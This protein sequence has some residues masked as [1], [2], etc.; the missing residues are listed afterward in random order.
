MSS[1]ATRSLSGPGVSL[2][3][4]TPPPLAAAVT[5]SSG[6]VFAS[7][8]GGSIG[9]SAT[10]SPGIGVLGSHSLNPAAAGA[11]TA[12]SA[13]PGSTPSTSSASLLVDL[14]EWDTRVQL[15]N[16]QRDS[17][18]LLQDLCGQLPIPDKFAS[19]PPA[20]HDAD[21]AAWPSGFNDPP[22]MTSLAARPQP[23]ETSARVDAVESVA[24]SSAPATSLPK[25][26]ALIDP[27]ET[28]HHFLSWYSQIEDLM[29]QGLADVY[30][31]HLATL[32]A[33]LAACNDLLSLV[34]LARSKLDAQST[35]YHFVQT[36]TSSLQNVCEKLLALQQHLA[37]VVEE[38]A[39]RLRRFDVLEPA[40]RLFSATGEG[41]CLDADFVPM[42][43]RLDDSLAFVQQNRGYKDA[44]LYLMK[45]RQCMT[46]GLTLIKLYFASSMRSLFQDIKDKLAN[47]QTNEP[48]PKSL[49]LSLFY[50]K[51][52]R[53]AEHL[54]P[55]IFEL[56]VRC[57]DHPEYYGLR[58]E[59]F[60][61][62]FNTRRALLAPSVAQAVSEIS[63]ES[64]ILATAKRGA[65]YITSLCTDECSL[66]YQ[67]FDGGEDDLAGYLDSLSSALYDHLRPM[68][69][70]EMRIDVLADLC[71]SLQ[72]H[73][74][75]VDSLSSRPRPVASPTD[76]PSSV[77]PTNL[78]GDADRYTDRV[79]EKVLQDAQERLVFR[80]QQYIKEEVEGFKPRDRELEVLARTE[81][82]PQP[83]ALASQSNMVPD[84]TTAGP[85]AVSVLA[86]SSPTTSPE[87]N[88]ST[89][90]ERTISFG[91][92]VYGGG[93]W[94][95]TL[96]RTLYILGKMYRSIPTSIFEDL[97][98]EAI[99]LCR[100]S[101]VSASEVIG[102]KKTR[103]DGQL[104]LI[105][106]LLMLRE[107]IAP[108]DSNF[109]RYEE[110]VDFA[111]LT[112]FLFNLTPTFLR[113]SATLRGTYGTGIKPSSVMLASGVSPTGAS[114]V[115]TSSTYSSAFSIFRRGIP[116]PRVFATATDA[117]A[118]VN[119][120]L[121]RVCED[122]ILETA[123]AVAEPASS[124]MVKVTAFRLRAE[125][126]RI[127][128]LAGSTAQVPAAESLGTLGAQAFAAP[129][130][131]I[132]AAEAV[133]DKVKEVLGGV[134]RKMADYLGDRRTEAVL[135]VHM[136]SN[137]MNAYSAFHNVVVLEHDPALLE[138]LPSVGAMSRFV[139]EVCEKAS[140]REAAAAIGTAA[141]VKAAP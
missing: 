101:V 50:V 127:P 122:L 77:F 82:L 85:S 8:G 88:A 113:L 30:R 115:A 102:K 104:F 6:G 90:D 110:R 9:G 46:R 96:Q 3:P 12:G 105:K 128:A 137:V 71:R 51:F 95:P 10:S 7:A 14:A 33:Y 81:K 32:S 62:Y 106:N 42:L 60:N 99:E 58:S 25:P 74:D 18:L 67:F 4:A 76:S 123:R 53:Q 125:R 107:Q 136:K 47:R 80:A 114:A 119:L 93:E 39:E 84:L 65:A 41:V 16:R 112:D 87:G 111:E 86:A 5:G 126:A 120:S 49:Q 24:S 135:V 59:C 40:V 141:V 83:N 37:E 118:A 78:D 28:N 109:V 48:L 129:R 64:S 1:I 13:P 133:R 35:Q 72:V 20:A 121:K 116:V 117:K 52:R 54:R 56:E 98:Q 79:V 94:Y 34:S 63:T 27:I 132:E 19:S 140:T 57:P 38:V 131:C 75:A 22:L 108:F 68:I 2:A 89:L 134:V 103:Q 100:K 55:L 43:A 31:S 23:E 92:L 29:E 73:V 11:A 44:E 138:D 66:F 36:K 97:A 21:G 69:L 124:F 91:K 45:F 15:T 139:D 130:K 17:V 26:L 61:A 70:R